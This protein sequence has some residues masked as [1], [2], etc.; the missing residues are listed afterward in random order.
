MLGA[1]RPSLTS[2]SGLLWKTPWRMSQT[3]KR[4]ARKRLKE[5]DGVIDT[6]MNSG[7]RCRALTPFREYPREA[8]LSAKEKYSVFAKNMAA[9]GGRKSL[10]K[11]PHYTKIHLTRRSPDGF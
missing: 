2:F 1:F 8:D 5:V 10:H 9:S 7:I 4:N 3:R 6:L 11:V